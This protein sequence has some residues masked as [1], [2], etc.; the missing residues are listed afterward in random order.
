[1]R[2]KP[3]NVIFPFNST[4][5]DVWKRF[6]ESDKT[7]EALPFAFDHDR[8]CFKMLYPHAYYDF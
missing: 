8:E 7:M 1:M 2:C 5:A 4:E 3:H 6:V